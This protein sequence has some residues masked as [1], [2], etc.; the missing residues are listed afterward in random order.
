MPAD[1]LV[2]LLVGGVLGFLA[3]VFVRRRRDPV[4]GLAEAKE[5]VE[6]VE[7]RMKGVAP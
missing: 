7:D 5:A 1:D 3:A 4:V 2:L 6:A